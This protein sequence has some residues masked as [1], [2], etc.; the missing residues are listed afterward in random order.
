MLAYNTRTFPLL[1]FVAKLENPPE[2]LV[3]K[4]RKAITTI[5][6]GPGNWVTFNYLKFGKDQFGLMVNL[7][8]IEDY[9]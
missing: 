6:T 8:D 3:K 2:W 4:T 1:S 5:A 9:T 7:K